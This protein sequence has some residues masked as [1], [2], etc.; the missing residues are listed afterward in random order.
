MP[1]SI[2]K[3]KG[4]WYV[5]TP[6]GLR[7]KDGYATKKEALDYLAALEIHAEDANKKDIAVPGE[8]VGFARQ[9]P[10]DFLPVRSTR[11]PEEIEGY[12]ALWGSPTL[13]DCWNTYF[14]KSRPPVM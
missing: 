13:R 12:V 14:D 9:R 3:R 8:A 4:K 11:N 7:P 6:D 1:Y 2:T 5:K 10:C